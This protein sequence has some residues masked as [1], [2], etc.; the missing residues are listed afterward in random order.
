LRTV[1]IHEELKQMY[2][3]KAKFRELQKLAL[4]AIM[5]S[6]SP[7]LVIIGTGVGKSLLFQ[8]LARSQKL[9]TTVVIVLLK[10]LERSLY[11]QC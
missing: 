7:I 3:D 2:K 9:G 11:K 4:E 8:L 6:K 5:S 10:S 1:D